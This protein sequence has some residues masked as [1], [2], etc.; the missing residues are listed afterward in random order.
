MLT[1]IGKVFNSIKNFSFKN[2]R[3]FLH[4][5]PLCILVRLHHGHQ[6]LGLT[7]QQILVEWHMHH[8]LHQLI[9]HSEQRHSKLRQ[10]LY[11]HDRLTNHEFSLELILKL[12]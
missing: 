1:M 12:L 3:C 9:D 10:L 11:E 6:Y 8:Q 4:L 7:I 2:F 5:R